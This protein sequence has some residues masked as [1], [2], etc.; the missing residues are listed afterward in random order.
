MVLT[1]N[2]DLIS[3]VIIIIIII[4]V[5]MFILLQDRAFE[6]IW[7]LFLLIFTFCMAKGDNSRASFGVSRRSF[8]FND[9]FPLF[10]FL[11]IKI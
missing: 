5:L 4:D 6:N 10:K 11:M 2:N 1:L 9:H 7:L 8:L 3:L